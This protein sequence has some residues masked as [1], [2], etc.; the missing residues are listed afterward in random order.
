VKRPVGWIHIAGV[1]VAL[2][3]LGCSDQGLTISAEINQS[4]SLAGDFA[5]ALPVNPLRWNVI[6]SE[7]S[8]KDSTMSTLYGNEQAV[9]CA[10]ASS[11]HDYP[12]G[13]VLS[14]VTWTQREDPRWFGAKIPDQVSS[15]EFVTVGKG[16]DDK[17]SYS[18][19]A[20]GGT[21]LKLLTTQEGLIPS[22]RAGYLLAQR[23]AVMP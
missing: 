11:Q 1:F 12:A 23:A 6:T 9:A 15:V 16:A 5:A 19:Q 2:S 18:Y 17:P 3:M 13:A 10:R 14:L 4:A 20:Y 21:P 7:V 22:E 8:Q